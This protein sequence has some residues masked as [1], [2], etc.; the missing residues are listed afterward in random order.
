MYWDKSINHKDLTGTDDEKGAQDG[1][2]REE[3]EGMRE[4]KFTWAF[5]DIET[6]M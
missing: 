3:E 4:K 1:Q 2:A 5:L 6:K